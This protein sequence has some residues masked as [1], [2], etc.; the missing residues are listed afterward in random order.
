MLMRYILGAMAAMWLADGLALLSVPL[1]VIRRIEESL[2][3]HPHLLRWQAADMCLGALLIVFSA[4]LPYQPLWAI[5]G[6]AM[7]LKGSLLAWGPETW[8]AS[9][10]AWCFAREAIDYRF[11]GL[12]LCAL[13]VL[14]L[15]AL[16]LV[17]R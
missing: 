11:V 14:L 12:G 7:S 8:R 3:R 5:T 17:T 4:E 6:V 1:L 9:L 10:L 16:G 13:A 15:H 2:Q